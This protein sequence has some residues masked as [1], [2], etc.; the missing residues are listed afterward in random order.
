M[1]ESTIYRRYKG[2][3]ELV[4]DAIESIRQEVIIPDTGSLIGDIDELVNNAAQVTL[5]PTGRQTAM[6]IVNSAGNSA[7]FA[8]IYQQK[9]L[10]PRRKAFAIII[11]RAKARKEIKAN[12]DT[13]LVFDAMSGI[14]LYAL[15]FPPTK[16]S[17]SQYVRRSLDLMLTGASS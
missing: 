15:V 13:N 7:R 4:A 16:E 3:E 1:V 5:H 12:L 14:M 9:Y 6:M 10:Q 8:Q 2:K 11:E 17:W